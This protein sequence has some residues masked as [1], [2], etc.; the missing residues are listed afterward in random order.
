MRGKT[1]DGIG[2]GF[3]TAY[4]PG[5]LSSALPPGS[6]K[7]IPKDSILIFQMHY[8]PNGVEQTDRSSVGLIFAKEPPKSKSAHDPPRN[9]ISPFRRATTTMK[10]PLRRRS[11][12]TPSC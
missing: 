1:A 12:R 11:T 10:R 8:T 5:E 9:A 3:L 4:A 2:D 7:H 6:A